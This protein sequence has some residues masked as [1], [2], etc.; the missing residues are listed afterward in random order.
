MLKALPITAQA[1]A[2]YGQLVAPG[3][4]APVI[5][6]DGH[7]K[8]YTDL[9]GLDVTAGKVG[10]SLFHAD[11]RAMPY[12]LELLERHPKGSQCFIPLDGSSFLVTVADDDDGTPVNPR[13]F[14]AGPD[15]PVNI[16]RNVWH[17]VLTPVSG[18][19][20]FAVIDAVECGPNLQEHQLAC[21]VLIGIE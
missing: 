6:N 15:Q 2:P 16:G 14:L 19:G 21:P 12:T 8:R 17:G 20:L 1:F 3:A 18:S 13:A 9:A 5:I 11:I 4:V 10:L 7:C